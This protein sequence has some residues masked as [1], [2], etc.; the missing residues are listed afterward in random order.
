VDP[1]ELIIGQTLLRQIIEHC[2]EEKP[3]EACGVLTGRQGRVLHAYATEN[4]K[5]SP[6]FYEV[7]PRQQEE[8]LAQMAA[9]GEELVAIYHS[10][11]SASA[12]PSQNDI[13]LAVHYPEAM[14]VIVSLVGPSDVRAFR[15]REG[16]VETVS[17]CSPT[18]VVGE[19]HDLRS[20][21]GS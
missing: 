19:W 18:D 13:R 4:A 12:M 8:I 3:F 16:Q 7:D 2:L 11:P 17:L 5:R 20:L 10:H 1:C 6:I 9:R 15:I 14:R 21:E